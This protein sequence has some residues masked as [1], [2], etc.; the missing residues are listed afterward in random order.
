MNTDEI[1]EL[2]E[3]SRKN[4]ERDGITGLLIYKQWN[5]AERANFLQILEGPRDLVDKAY[6]KIAKDNRHHTIL[7]LEQGDI[8]ARNF[9]SWAMGFKN[10]E[11]NELKKLPGFKDVDENSFNPDD[12]SEQLEATLETIKF[13]YDAD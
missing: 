4:N 8:P 7:P 12:F 3:I 1:S 6:R 5:D 10:I 2:L 9:G 13:F 11:T